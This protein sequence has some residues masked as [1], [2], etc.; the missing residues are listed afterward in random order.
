MQQKLVLKRLIVLKFID[1]CFLGRNLL[2][3]VMHKYK[4]FQKI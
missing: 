2:C 4:Y 3:V 1:L